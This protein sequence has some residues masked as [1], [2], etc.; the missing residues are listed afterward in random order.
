[1]LWST[2]WVCSQVH[3]QACS[4]WY[5][6]L[7]LIAHSQPAWLYSPKPALNT[8]SSTLLSTLSTS[9]NCTRWHIPSLLDSPLPSKLSRRAQVHSEYALKLS[10]KYILKYTLQHTLKDTSNCTRWH[11]PSPLGSTLSSTLWRGKT[12][13][14]PPDYMVPCMLLGVWSRAVLSW[15]CQAPGGGWLVAGGWWRVA[16]SGHNHDIS[17]HLS[18]NLIFSVP[19]VTRSQDAS[20]LWCWEL[21]P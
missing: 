10:S 5:S 15:R 4:Q 2:L 19:T 1:M 17:Q 6:Q 20:P 18:L 11:T 14:I 16:Y 9:P 13:P 3:S 8:L 21:Q 12:I 7:Y